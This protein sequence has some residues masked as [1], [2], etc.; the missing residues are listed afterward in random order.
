MQLA[1]GPSVHELLFIDVSVCHSLLY[2]VDA[3]LSAIVFLCH[4]I[5]TRQMRLVYT[6]GVQLAKPL[7]RLTTALS[8]NNS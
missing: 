4:A 1:V 8:C 2:N 6:H 5:S 7:A 3:L